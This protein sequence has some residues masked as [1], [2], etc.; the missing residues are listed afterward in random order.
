[1]SRCGW[2]QINEVENRMESRRSEATRIGTSDLDKYL[3]HA[4]V[5]QDGTFIPVR[6]ET[7]WN[8][9]LWKGNS[10]REGAMS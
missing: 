6:L 5:R 2:D 10:C 3:H 9:G 7:D 1:M 4:L 8:G